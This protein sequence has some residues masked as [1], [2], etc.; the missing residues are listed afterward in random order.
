MEPAG[1]QQNASNKGGFTLVEV[2]V[3]MF[4]MAI[5]FTAAFGAYFLGLNMIE[6][7]REEVRAAQIIQSEMERLRTKNWYQL[8]KMAAGS[9]QSFEPQGS[10]IKQY[11]KDY[12]AQRWVI[13]LTPTPQMWIILKVN[14]TDSKGKVREQWFNAIITQGG[15]NDYYYREV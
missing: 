4:L 10:F 5:V 9:A 3:G 13:N 8:E 2:L 6:D 7:A 1:I 14:W 12:T 15:L 11:A